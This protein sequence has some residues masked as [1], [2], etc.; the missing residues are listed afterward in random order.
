MDLHDF[1]DH[2]M[3]FDETL[4]EMVT[5]NLELAA[6]Y[7]GDQKAEHYLLKAYVAEPESLTVLVGLYR[8]Y[9]YGHKLDDALTVAIRVLAICAKKMDFSRNWEQMNMD[10]LACGVLSHSMGMVRFYLSTLK[11]A[12]YINVRLGNYDI[13][14]AMMEKVLELDSHDRLGTADLIKT[15]TRHINRPR[16]VENGDEKELLVNTN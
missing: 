13:G 6:E 5:Q 10:Y 15:I 12:G 1:K 7:Y 14:I 3:Y 4:P 9:F 16:L 2:T 11:C 8:Y